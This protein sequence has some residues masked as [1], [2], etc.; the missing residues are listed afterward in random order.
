MDKSSLNR[1][2]FL[3]IGVAAT[4]GIAAAT[5]AVASNSKGSTEDQGKTIYRTLG[6]TGI[7]VPVVSMGVMRADN[8]NIVK[9][10]YQTG[11]TFFDTAHGYQDGRNEEMVGNVLKDKPR[12]SFVVATKIHPDKGTSTEKFLEMVDTSLKRL[13]MDYVDILYLHAADNSQYLYNE[14]YT[15]ALKT[16]K[17]QGIARHIGFSTHKNMAD[18]INVAVERGFYEVALT[19]YNFRL[20]DDEEMTK[21]LKNASDAGMGIVGMKNM[22]G[23]WLDEAKTKPVNCKAAL[24][25]ALSS[26]YV[27]TCIPGIVSFEM[28]MENWSVA[29]DVSLSPEERDDLQLALNETGMFCKGCNTCSGQCKHDLPVS[30]L[31]RSYMYNYAY[32]YPAK[33]W[34]TVVDAG[35]PDDPCTGCDECTVTCKSGFDV[36]GK[37]TDIARIRKV[38]AEFL[39]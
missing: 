32:A 33:A 29:S 12:D 23:G 2:K 20:A 28:L 3:Q 37:I 34:K 17:E 39:V 38:P 14:N 26:P 13:Q 6:K 11:I 27:H 19:S 9:G 5:S 24:K 8:P 16:A 1:R 22:A 36:R 18:M 31:M 35:V 15:Q 4:A 30:D 25:W 10:A 21:A 7:R